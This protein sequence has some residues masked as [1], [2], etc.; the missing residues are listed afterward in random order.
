MIFTEQDLRNKLNATDEQ[1]ELV[2]AY[3]ETFPM[4][5]NG[6]TYV[7]GR[8]LYKGLSVRQDFTDWIKKQIELASANETDYT[9][10]WLHESH[11]FKRVAKDNKVKDTMDFNN[12]SHLFKRVAKDDNLQQM[13]ANGY[14]QDYI[15]TTELA[16]EI[17]MGVGFAPRTNAETKAKS[18]IARK[19][20]ITMESMIKDLISWQKVREKE[21]ENYLFYQECFMDYLKRQGIEPSGIYYACSGDILN[22]M[23]IGM[24]AK[25]FKKWKEVNST[26]DNLIEECNKRISFVQDNLI[27]LYQTDTDI[28]DIFD[29]LFKII[30]RE[31]N[32]DYKEI[33]ITEMNRKYHSIITL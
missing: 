7:S 3:Q 30:K 33:F 21:K 18:K 10:V 9:I 16:K 8:D 4:L 17:C 11:P 31:F 20:F 25:E 24:G 14:Y 29:I 6:D 13:R 22:L 5:V 27:T 23:A 15:L 1:V 28:C 2:L 26:R 19:Y 32:V 12:L